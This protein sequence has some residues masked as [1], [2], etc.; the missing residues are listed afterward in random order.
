LPSPIDTGAPRTP[1]LAKAALTL[2]AYARL[3]RWGWP[4]VLG[5]VVFAAQYATLVLPYPWSERHY[6]WGSARWG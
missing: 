6:E 5:T 3:G 2:V 1:G 4:G